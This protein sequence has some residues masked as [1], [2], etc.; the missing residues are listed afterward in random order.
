MPVFTYRVELDHPVEDVFRWHTRPGAF[1]RLSPPWEDVRIRHQDEGLEVGNRVVLGLRKGVAELKWEVKHTAFEANRLFVDE[2]VTGP[3]SR[4]RHEHRFHDLGSGRSAVEDVVDWEAPLGSLGRTFSGSF[5][6]ASLRRLFAFR[7]RR[8]VNDLALHRRYGG[9]RLTVAVTGATG[10]VGSALTAFLRTGGHRVIPI[11]RGRGE[12]ESDWIRWD[13]AKGILDGSEL[14]G[15][16]AVVHLAGESIAGVRWTGAKKRAI[17]E[18]RVEG[19]ELISRVLADLNRPPATFISGSAVGFYGDRG[20]ELLTE[21]APA[22]KGFL[23]D[24]CRAWEKATHA[25]RAVGIRTLFLRTGVVLSPEGGMLNTVQ[26]PFRLGLGGRLGSGRQYVPWIDLDD[27]VGLILHLLRTR[28]L[29]G[30]VNATAPNPV[31]NAAFTTVLGRVLSRPT[32][33]PAPALAIRAALGEMGDQLLLSGQRAVPERAQGT[34]YDFLF[35]DLE[36]SLRHQLGRPG[37]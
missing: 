14:E 4:W 26:L 17:R 11:S 2:Q 34:G 8:L 36:E 29:R 12:G 6:E 27:E 3:F 15:V 31:P 1:Q 24:V 33:L 16:D 13:P 25:A 32:L 10:L 20:D 21:D 35:P 28:E 22:G 19:T 7:E 30:A 23:A 5:I 37:G 18:S 9:P